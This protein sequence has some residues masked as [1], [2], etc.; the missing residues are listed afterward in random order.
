[1]LAL[2]KLA[3]SQVEQ[4]TEI[5]YDMSFLKEIFDTVYF[6]KGRVTGL[7]GKVNK[8][9]AMGTCRDGLSIKE[10]I[11][12]IDS[13]EERDTRLN[14][15]EREG[16]TESSIAHMEGR[17]EELDITQRTMLKHFSKLTTIEAIKGEMAEMN[18]RSQA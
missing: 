9:D 10:L 14:S 17:V 2:K 13:L 16:S 11:F 5:E 7:S 3:K 18:T 6:L 15:L 1:M 8:I 12:R 4:L